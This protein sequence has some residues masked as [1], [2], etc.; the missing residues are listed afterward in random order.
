MTFELAV[1]LTLIIDNLAEF[2]YFLKRTILNLIFIRDPQFLNF[3][4]V[5]ILLI[6]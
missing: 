2:A 5:S 1:H 4:F 3:W 6:I